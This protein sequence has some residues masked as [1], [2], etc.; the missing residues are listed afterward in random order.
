MLQYRIDKANSQIIPTSAIV[1]IGVGYRPG[2]D[3]LTVKNGYTLPTGFTTSFDKI[4]GSLNIS[5]SA[6]SSATMS[7]LEDLLKK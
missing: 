1:K 3:I 7:D 6:T 4:T 2:E 5:N